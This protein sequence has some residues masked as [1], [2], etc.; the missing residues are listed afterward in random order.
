LWPSELFA[1]ARLALD[2]TQLVVEAASSDA[3]PLPRHRTGS[4]VSLAAHNTGHSQVFGAVGLD[5]E[6]SEASA[7]RAFGL[8]GRVT[9]GTG[10]H[11]LLQTRAG[12]GPCSAFGGRKVLR[13]QLAAGCTIAGVG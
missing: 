1:D 3:R 7:F 9:S 13:A 4:R 8:P 11:C 10:D 6:G 2:A 5:I 12:V